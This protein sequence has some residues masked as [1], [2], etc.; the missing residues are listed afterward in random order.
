MNYTKKGLKNHPIY[1]SIKT[2]KYFKINLTKGIQDLYTKN[3]KTLIKE[4][5]DTNKW[6]DILHSW[7]GRINIV[8]M[9]IPTQDNLQSQ[10]NFFQNTNGNFHRT[11]NFVYLWRIHFDIWQN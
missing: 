10:C 9:S 6:K 1:G 7:I 11:N 2:Y 8:K 5:E 4:I 3:Y